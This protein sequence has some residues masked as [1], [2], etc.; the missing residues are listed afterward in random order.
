MQ[1]VTLNVRGMSCNHCVRSI[2][3]ALNKIGATATVDL[4]AGTVAVEYDEEKHNLELIIATIEE[5]GYVVEK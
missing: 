2:L 5:Q 3:G 4:E 1:N